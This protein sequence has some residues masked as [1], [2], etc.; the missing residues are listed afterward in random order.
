MKALVLV[1]SLFI[2]QSAYAVCGFSPAPCEFPTAPV[3]TPERFCFAGICNNV[4]GQWFSEFYV[5]RSVPV[6]GFPVMG[7]GGPCATG[8]FPDIANQALRDLAANA[9]KINRAWY[10]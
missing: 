5:V 7:W 6:T 2:T 4:E 3:E 1:V 8:N 10:R 9:D